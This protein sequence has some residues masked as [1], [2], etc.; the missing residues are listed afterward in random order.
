VYLER[1]LKA[2]RK[3]KETYFVLLED[4]VYVIDRLPSAILTHTMIGA[5]RHES[6]GLGPRAI[7]PRIMVDNLRKYNA[8]IDDHQYYGGCGGTLFRT[9]F[10]ANLNIDVSTL[11]DEYGVLNPGYDSDILLS[12]I[13][14]RFGGDIYGPPMELGET[15]H[16]DWNQR[17]A[18]GKIKVLHNYKNHYHQS[19]TSEEYNTYF[20]TN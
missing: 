3:I 19:L 10:F 2:A 13:T 18:S 9:E 5:N 7:M 20:E 17:V 4:D 12:Y 1:F 14:L 6:E 16:P 15:I 8:N 11:V